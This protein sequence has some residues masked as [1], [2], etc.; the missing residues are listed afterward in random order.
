MPLEVR[1]LDRKRQAQCPANPDY[2][3]GMV[4]DL[5][6]GMEKTCSI[7]LPYPAPRCGL[8]VVTC[9]ACGESNAI[10]TAGRLDDPRKVIFGCHLSALHLADVGTPL[11]RTVICSPYDECAR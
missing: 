8:Y 10:T 3:C 7:A 6:E 2:P 4:M 1:W 9:E 11:A 5:S